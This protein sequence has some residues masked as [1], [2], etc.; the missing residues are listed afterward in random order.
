MRW[1][2]IDVGTNSVKVL[3]GEVANGAVLPILEQSEQTRLGQG[4][5]PDHRLQAGPLSK[6]A[7][8]VSRF[9]AEAAQAGAESVR[10]IATSAARDAV[11][12]GELLDAVRAAS[13]LAVE[14]ISGE[15]EADWVYAGVRTDPALKDGSLLILEIGGGSSEFIL[16]C[17]AH[18]DFRKS[19]G[20]GTVRLAEMIHPDDPPSSE[21]WRTCRG[22]VEEFM[23]REV[24]P[25]LESR[26]RRAG[27]GLRLVG[28]G[29]TASILAAME[30]GLTRFDRKLIDGTILSR[31]RVWA[32]QK[33]LWGLPLAARQRLPG[34]PPNRAD[35]ILFGVAIYAV[36]MERWRFDEVH[37][38][39]RGLRFGALLDD[40]NTEVTR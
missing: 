40:R 13:G 36:V 19:V 1:A 7:Q 24:G 9:A 14:V 12:R 11:N 32:L 22:W 30:H 39:T 8:A 29:G 6:T 34:L 3:V 28:T 35:V 2:V 38:S 4:F 26:L 23:A 16:G 20:I 21:D 18:Q 33:F 10:V 5:Y 25:E 37:V 17:G 31:E 27:Q 15:R